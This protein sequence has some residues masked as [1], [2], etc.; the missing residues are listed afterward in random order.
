VAF[1]DPAKRSSP[2][3]GMALRRRCWCVTLD[4]CRAGS[5]GKRFSS[6]SANGGAAAIDHRLGA[7]KSE[8]T[9]A[10]P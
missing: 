9:A 6:C 8:L 4:H 10:G 7:I 2:R 5:D 3:T 1:T